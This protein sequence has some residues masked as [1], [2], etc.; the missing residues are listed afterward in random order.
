LRIDL[1]DPVFKIIQEHVAAQ[2]VSQHFEATSEHYV[3]HNSANFPLG[4]EL[5][6][7]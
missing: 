4:K 6:Y 2:Y 5:L 3:D 7:T 1:H